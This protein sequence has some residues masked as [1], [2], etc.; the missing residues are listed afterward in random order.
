M[1]KM[2]KPMTAH[3]K[4][5]TMCF[6]FFTLQSYAKSLT[7]KKFFKEFCFAVDHFLNLWDLLQYCFVFWLLDLEAFETLGP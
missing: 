3:T 6:A 4:P 7:K 5:L 2:Y 1:A